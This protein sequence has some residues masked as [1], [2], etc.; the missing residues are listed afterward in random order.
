[1][2][3]TQKAPEKWRANLRKILQ[4]ASFPDLFSS[5][6]KEN[7]IPSRFDGQSIKSVQVRV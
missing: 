1:M 6:A 7:N 5:A 2:L 4:G 3:K